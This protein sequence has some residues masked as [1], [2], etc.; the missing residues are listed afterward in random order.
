MNSVI[1]WLDRFV[2]AIKGEKK[3]VKTPK[4]PIIVDYSKCYWGH[5]CHGIGS[6]EGRVAGWYSGYR[7]IERNDYL[8]LKVANTDRPHLFRVEKC[9]YCGNPPDM[10]FATVQWLCDMNDAPP[11]IVALIEKQKTNPPTWRFLT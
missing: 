6:D 9:E 5:N 8:I 2:C 3:P 11:D 7:N 1:D 4:E 10:Y